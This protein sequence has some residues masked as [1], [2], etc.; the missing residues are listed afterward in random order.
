MLSA[1]GGQLPSPTTS[2]VSGR[3]QCG[4]GGGGG[5]GEVIMG[6]QHAVVTRQVGTHLPYVQDKESSSLGR[7]HR[8][9]KDTKRETRSYTL[10]G[11]LRIIRP[12]T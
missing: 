9:C 5:G 11:M 2:V 1:A 6:L 12:C 3:G 4:G 7:A 8:I 10:T